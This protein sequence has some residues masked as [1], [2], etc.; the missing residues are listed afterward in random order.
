[1]SF[2]EKEGGA[3]FP[4]RNPRYKNSTMPAMHVV[5]GQKEINAPVWTLQSLGCKLN[6]ETCAL[7]GTVTF[8]S[9]HL[10]R[11]STLSDR[12]TDRL[13]KEVTYRL[14]RQVFGTQQGE[15][16]SHW[17]HR[18]EAQPPKAQLQSCHVLPPKPSVAPTAHRI[19]RSCSPHFLSQP[20]RLLSSSYPLALAPRTLPSFCD[21]SSAQW[22]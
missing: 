12:R 16:L 2:P 11:D 5:R 7:Q 17:S 1:M 6:I 13:Q 19:R 15:A 10:L 3:A 21:R 14:G 8:E 20:G 22:Y 18:A 4:G 9:L